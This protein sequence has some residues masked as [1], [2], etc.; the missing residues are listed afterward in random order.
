MNIHSADEI[1]VCF[2]LLHL[3]IRTAT[4]KEIYLLSRIIIIHSNIHV[5]TAENNP[6]FSGNEF[7]ATHRLVSRLEVVSNFLL[8]KIKYNRFSGEKTEKNPWLGWMIIDTLYAITL[9]K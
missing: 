6:L 3:D 2:P 4:V 9:L 5:I 8:L 7:A 1:I